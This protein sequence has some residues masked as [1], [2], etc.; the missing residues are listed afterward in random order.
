MFLATPSHMHMETAVKVAEFVLQESHVPP[1]TTSSMESSLNRAANILKE[2]PEVK[3]EAQVRELNY[4]AIKK[5]SE[6][7]KLITG[8]SDTEQK[9]K[10]YPSLLDLF[11]RGPMPVSDQQRGLQ[12][13]VAAD[14]AKSLLQSGLDS[15]HLSPQAR[16]LKAKAAAELGKS[17]AVGKEIELSSRIT[18]RII[19]VPEVGS[20]KPPSQID[21]TDLEKKTAKS[22]AILKYLQRVSAAGYVRSYDSYGRVVPQK[23]PLTMAQ[24]EFELKE[25]MKYHQESVNLYREFV[26][27]VRDSGNDRDVI[28]KAQNA[29][30]L[31]EDFEKML[32]SSFKKIKEAKRKSSVADTASDASIETIDLH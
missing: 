4:Q 17:L 8:T 16:G 20:I 14:F 10:D 22:K 15:S 23:F 9:K 7:Q 18:N 21:W 1:L 26:K 24:M 29:Q 12:A 19:P 13:K 2:G 6:A 5:G 25:R 32:R 28:K 3:T 27:A 11:A 30:D 31:M